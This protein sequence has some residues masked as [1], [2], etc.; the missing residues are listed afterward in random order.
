MKHDQ[1]ASLRRRKKGILMSFLAAAAVLRRGRLGR[2]WMIA[3]LAAGVLTIVQ[4][5]RTRRAV[6]RRR[7][8]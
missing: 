5:G 1:N 4:P 8:F 2:T 6:R 7:H 3:L